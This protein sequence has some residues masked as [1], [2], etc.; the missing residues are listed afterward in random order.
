MTHL[1]K[2]AVLFLVLDPDSAAGLM[3]QLDDQELA[4]VSAEMAKL[5]T[6]SQELQNEVLHE[7]SPVAVEAVSAISGGVARTQ[8]LLEKSVGVFRASDFIARVSPERP[9][10]AAMQQIIEMDP[11]HIFNVLR[12]E[13]LQTI[14]L[15]VSFMPPEKASELLSLVRPELRDQVV[16]RLATLAP[17]SIEVVES[18]AD[19]LQRKLPTTRPRALNHTGGVKVAAQVLNA[20]PKD[21]SDS[22]LTS[23]RDKNADLGDAVLK[24]MFTFDELQRLDSKTIQKILQ[25]V[26][27]R[28]LAQALQT[29]SDGL[30]KALLSC[31]SKRAAENVKEEIGL[32][33][34]PNEDQIEA[35]QMEIIDVVRRLEGEGAISLDQ[36]RQK[37]K[38]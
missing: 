37:N 21:V 33:G 12:H 32:L 28:S 25:E 30:K 1:Q 27:M 6:I 36:L 8:A 18:V 14:A 19:E 3:K 2:L 23:L 4:A 11:R 26:D 17:T 10:V 31:I 34:S 9:R 13:Q 16:E 20:M 29:A 15:V 5:T 38:S 22:I 35:A 24:K 7:F